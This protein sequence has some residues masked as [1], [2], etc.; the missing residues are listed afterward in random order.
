MIKNEQKMWIEIFPRKTYR[1]PEAEEKMLNI[2][3]IREVQI[4]TTMRYH[5]TPVRMATI[6]KPINNKCWRGCGEK[7]TLVHSW[8][9]C[10]FVQPLWR[11]VWRFLKKLKIEQPYDPAV[12]LLGIYPRKMKTVICKD[13]CTPMLTAALF[14]IAKIWKQPKCSTD[15]GI[16]KLW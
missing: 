15:E 1:W 2:V 5:L 11:T 7:G 10:K 14:T 9:E 12:P 13:T 3:N 8:W 4:K 6:K 16:K